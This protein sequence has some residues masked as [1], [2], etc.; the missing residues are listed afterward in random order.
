MNP[1]IISHTAQDF[2]QALEIIHLVWEIAEKQNH[3]PNIKLHSYKQLEFELFT[4]DVGKVTKKDETLWKE[5]D[6]ILFQ[7]R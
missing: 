3:H 7:Y 5:I 1:L 6:N 4:H 2:A